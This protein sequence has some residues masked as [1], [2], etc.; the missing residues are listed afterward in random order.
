MMPK[1]NCPFCSSRTRD[2]ANRWKLDAANR[3]IRQLEAFIT[4]QGAVLPQAS[5]DVAGAVEIAKLESGERFGLRDAIRRRAFE[6]AAVVLDGEGF[7]GSAEI[8]RGLKVG[9]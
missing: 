8:V 4:A 5:A 6:D 9:P 3:R 1:Q 7:D 2:T